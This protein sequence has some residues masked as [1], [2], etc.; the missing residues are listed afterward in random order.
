MRDVMAQMGFAGRDPERR[1]GRSSLP[2]RRRINT[3]PILRP[4]VLIVDDHRETREMYAWCMRAAGWAVEEA[5][6]GEVTLS[7][8]AAF[9]PDVIVI[10]LHLPLVDGLEAT[11]RLRQDPNTE[12]ITIV[13]C[14]GME[15]VESE[16]LARTAGCDEFV[17]KPCSPEDLRALLEN[18]VPANGGTSW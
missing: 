8:A 2:P 4:R 3:G 16:L 7:L 5:A 10:D 6:D 13:V 14:T 17:S 12:A 11:R 15:P 18:L 9:K 1:P